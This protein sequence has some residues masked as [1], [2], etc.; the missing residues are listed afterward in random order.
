[1]FNRSR[2]R[3]AGIAGALLFVS[4]AVQAQNPPPTKLNWYRG[5]TH[6]HTL[7]SDGDAT[8][9][10]VVRWFRE[11]D[12]QFLFITDHEYITDVGPLN[13]LFGAAERFLV[14]PG[15]EIT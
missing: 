5:N 14:L 1:M 6:T 11:H 12:Y 3:P 15:Q 2:L 7:N 10:A 9:D 4:M 13:A 8:P